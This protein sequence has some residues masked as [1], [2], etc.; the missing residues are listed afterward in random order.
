MS[1]QNELKNV[2][3]IT[4]E[5]YPEIVTFEKVVES[6]KKIIEK[7]DNVNVLDV[8][9]DLDTRED[10][11]DD[12]KYSREQYYDLIKLGKQ[13]ISEL[14][15]YAASAEETQP[16]EAVSKLI[17]VT[18]EVTRELLELQKTIKSLKESSGI[19]SVTN[20]S[21]YVGSTH[22]LQ[23]LIKDANTNTNTK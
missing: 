20:N 16:Y 1:K 21:I 2:L 3:K 4:S 8:D 15:S 17:K 22:D 18:S 9:N 23:K 14:L 7:Y 11:I 12:Y 19:K 10:I 5:E 13:A 6:T